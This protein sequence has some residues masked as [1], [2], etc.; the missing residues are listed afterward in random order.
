MSV[1][2]SPG[3][4]RT[5][6]RFSHQRWLCATCGC[7]LSFVCGLNRETNRRTTVSGGPLKKTQPCDSYLLFLSTLHHL[8]LSLS[9]FFFLCAD[10]FTCTSNLRRLDRHMSNKRNWFLQT[11]RTLHSAHIEHHACSSW[12][13]PYF[14]FWRLQASP[15]RTS[16]DVIGNIGD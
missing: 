6:I 2:L 1:A 12:N 4:H 16:R 13:S 3:S 9:L 10:S 7:V 8:S 14:P 15:L 5:P 11:L